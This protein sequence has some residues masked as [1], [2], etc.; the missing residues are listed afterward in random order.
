MLEATT[1]QRKKVQYGNL[2]GTIAKQSQWIFAGKVF[3]V[4][5]GFATS[6]LLARILGPSLLGRY[7]LGLTVILMATIFSVLNFQL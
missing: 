5:V 4:V 7:Q 2:L 1:D 3:F 6:A